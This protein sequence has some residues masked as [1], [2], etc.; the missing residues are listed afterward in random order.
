MSTLS[1]R[2]QTPTPKMLTSV[3]AF[4]AKWT[5][6]DVTSSTC[7]RPPAKPVQVH[8]PLPL[9]LKSPP[10]HQAPHL[11]VTA[12]C[13]HAQAPA[14][15][16]TR[17]PIQRAHCY[18]ATPVH[19]LRHMPHSTCQST[20]LLYRPRHKCPLTLLPQNPH[21]LLEK[22]YRISPTPLIYC[23]LPFPNITFSF[24]PRH[25]YSCLF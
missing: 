14:A 5:L 9:L 13:R 15:C 2:S 25:P 19:I 12:P 20:S 1:Q 8:R 16:Q 3:P 17:S 18:S 11:P 10:E 22:S 24:F 23:Q 7:L 6:L 21:L 4:R